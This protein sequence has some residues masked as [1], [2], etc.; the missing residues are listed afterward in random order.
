MMLECVCGDGDVMGHQIY[1]FLFNM[2]LDQAIK[3][4]PNSN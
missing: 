3:S 2:C 4:F 1:L